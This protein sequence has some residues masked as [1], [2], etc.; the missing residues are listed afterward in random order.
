MPWTTPKTG[1]T[2][3]RATALQFLLR[4]GRLVAVGHGIGRRGFRGHGSTAGGLDRP[5]FAAALEIPHGLAAATRH[6]V[7]VA[8]REAEDGKSA[9]DLLV[10]GASARLENAA[11][12]L[13]ALVARLRLDAEDLA[14]VADTARAY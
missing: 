4:A 6:L 13:A 9:G 12:L 2:C 5:D 10:A 3:N 14:L 7:I 11:R 8:A 1:C